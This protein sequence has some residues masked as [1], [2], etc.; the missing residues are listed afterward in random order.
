MLSHSN[1]NTLFLK[2]SILLDVTDKQS[3]LTLKM[4]ALHSFETSATLYQFTR[5]HILE[6]SI[7]HNHSRENSRSHGTAAWISLLYY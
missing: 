4:K 1:E 3:F 6:D 2:D 5:R 7:I